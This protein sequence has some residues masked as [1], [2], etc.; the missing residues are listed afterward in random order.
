MGT[1]FMGTWFYGDLVLWGLALWGLAFM[2]T[3]H[4][5]DWSGFMGTGV[6]LSGLGYMGTWL[7]KDLAGFMRTW[8]YVEL[9]WRGSAL[10]PVLCKDSLKDH[11]ASSP[12][13]APFLKQMPR[14]TQNH[15]TCNDSLSIY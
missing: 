14:L 10:V 3:W 12:N 2:G 5:E 1:C 6:A 4:Y 11:L 13:L 9:V 15:R 7:Y 8:S